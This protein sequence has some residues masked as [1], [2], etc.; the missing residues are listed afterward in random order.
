MILTDF[1]TIFYRE[2]TLIVALTSVSD[3]CKS[4]EYVSGHR[5]VWMREKNKDSEGSKLGLSEIDRTQTK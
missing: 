3:T 4:V 2:I 5:N 1:Q